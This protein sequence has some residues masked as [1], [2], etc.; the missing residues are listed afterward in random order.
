VNQIIDIIK[1]VEVFIRA[2][3]EVKC[4]EAMTH[5]L[6]D[7]I[8]DYLYKPEVSPDRLSI[9]VRIYWEGKVRPYPI[10]ITRS[11]TITVELAGQKLS[12]SYSTPTAVRKQQLEHFLS[13]TIARLVLRG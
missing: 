13:E 11:Q 12:S 6:Y 3:R 8:Q 7:K 1:F 5:P 9:T 2:L 4:K 10:T